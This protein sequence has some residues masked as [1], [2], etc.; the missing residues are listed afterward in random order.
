MEWGIRAEKLILC[1]IALPHVTVK[2]RAN[3]LL[4]TY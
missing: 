4:I 3:G 2:I 1:R